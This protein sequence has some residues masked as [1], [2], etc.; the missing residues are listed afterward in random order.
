MRPTKECPVCLSTFEMTPGDWFRWKNRIYCSSK[1]YTIGR[2]GK[3]HPTNRIII[4]IEDRF[5]EK[6]NKD[7]EIHPVL[8]TKCWLWN[9]AKHPA[10]Y[11]RIGRGHKETTPATHVSW[12]IYTGKEVPDGMIIM[13]KCDNPPCCNP[14]H[15]ELGTHKTNCDDMI[16][17]GRKVLGKIRYGIENNLTQISTE[18]VQAIKEMW[19]TDLPEWGDGRTKH[20]EKIMAKFNVSATTVKALV[21]GKRRM[22]G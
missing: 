3:P 2:V 5:W 14:D 12:K 6:V 8:G 1:C 16:K 18:D 9:G 20:R 13:H 4:P 17:K 21:A 10:G 19:I 11:G 7:G 15:L 22:N